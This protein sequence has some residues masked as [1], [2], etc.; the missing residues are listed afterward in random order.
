MPKLYSEKK[1]LQD[2][3]SVTGDVPVYPSG[4]VIFPG[5]RYGRGKTADLS[6]AEGIS[7]WQQSVREILRTK[8]TGNKKNVMVLKKDEETSA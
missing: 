6:S 7:L 1:C 3:S 8:R 5:R 2:C 4:Y